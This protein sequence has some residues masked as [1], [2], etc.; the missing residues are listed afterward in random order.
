M[1]RY[2]G[3][4]KDEYHTQLGTFELIIECIDRESE[5]VLL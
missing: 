1:S 3:T 4:V 2:K 5:G